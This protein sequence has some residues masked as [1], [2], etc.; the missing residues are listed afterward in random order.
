MNVNFS[1]ENDRHLAIWDIQRRHLGTF[2]IILHSAAL[3]RFS[4][5]FSLKHPRFNVQPLARD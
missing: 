4:Y 5:G 1:N 3:Y 2:H